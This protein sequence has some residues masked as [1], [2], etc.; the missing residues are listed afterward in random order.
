MNGFNPG[1]SSIMIRRMLGAAHPIRPP[2]MPRPTSMPHIRPAINLHPMM[3]P[4]NRERG[5]IIDSPL[6]PFD[7]GILSPG[8]GRSDDIKMHV[9]N[10]SYVMPAWAV[11]HIGQGNSVNGMTL[12]KM[13]FGAPQQSAGGPWGAPSPQIHKGG[14]GIPSAPQLRPAGSPPP[15]LI[16]GMSTR[17]WRNSVGRMAARRAPATVLCRST[18][19][20]VSSL[21]RQRKWRRS[22]M[23]TSTRATG[24]LT[25][26]SSN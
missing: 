20:A 4:M 15:M 26:G 13:M 24:F 21:F 18:R 25:V 7:G 17:H 9:D 11:S 6:Q 3:R 5:G 19:A 22:G 23:A 16:P 10:G 2:A 14:V 12:L 1:P 8:A